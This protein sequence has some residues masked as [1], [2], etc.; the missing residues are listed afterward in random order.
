MPGDRAVGDDGKSG[1]E[2]L[3]RGEAAGILDQHISC[4]HQS[5]HIVGP[6]DDD[7]HTQ[8]NQPSPE[9]FI[10]AAHRDRDVAATGNSADRTADAP[11]P[12]GAGDDESHPI[13]VG[14]AEPLAGRSTVSGESTA[15]DKRHA[16]S[17][18]A[19][20]LAS[21]L[22]CAGGVHTEVKVDTRVYPEGMDAKVGDV[23]DDRDR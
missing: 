4:G 11:H 3:H 8:P 2:R 17:R 7:A 13:I 1:R 22:V 21:R 15:S 12:P 5:L 16:D 9:P 10:A 18:L 6:S 23:S 19:S 20:R 14:Q